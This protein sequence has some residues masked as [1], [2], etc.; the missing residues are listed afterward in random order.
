[1]KPLLNKIMSDKSKTMPVLSFPLTGVLGCSSKELVT[2]S[3][4]QMKLM[5]YIADNYPVGAVMNPM[6]LSVEAE[7]FGAEVLF[8]ENGVPEVLNGVI[9]DILDADKITIPE[10]GAGRTGLFVEGI[11]KAKAV[12]S[13]TPVLCGIIG[14]FSLAGRLFDMTELMMECFE[15][16]DSVKVLLSKT[17]GFIRSYISAM[18]SAGADGVIIAEPAAGLLSEDMTIEFSTS[19]VK[20]IFDSVDDENFLTGYHNCGGSVKSMTESLSSLNADI[21]HFGN[22]V[23]LREIL[24]DMP[25]DSAVMGNLDPLLLKSGSTSDIRNEL[26]NVYEHC[27]SYDNFMISTGCDI[28]SEISMQNLDTYFS[29]INEIYCQKDGN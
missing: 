8:P 5:K 15:N 16:P 12:I 3:D 11:R 7:A 4:L 21:Y 27:S 2:S 9:S 29:T 1:M 14:P 6:D 23:N 10:I 22:S 28:P 13:G 24:P 25:A 17:S 18:K 19:Y 20:E 26:I